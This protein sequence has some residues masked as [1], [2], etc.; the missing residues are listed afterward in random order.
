V[1]ISIKTQYFK[2]KKKTNISQIRPLVRGTRHDNE[3][4]E[5]CQLDCNINLTNI[6]YTRSTSKIQHNDHQIPFSRHHA[7]ANRQQRALWKRESEIQRKENP[8]TTQAGKCSSEVITSFELQAELQ[9]QRA[10][11][12]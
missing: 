10:A 1:L 3:A 9:G 4:G 12:I 6:T 11:K 2:L 5:Q 8:P 7:I